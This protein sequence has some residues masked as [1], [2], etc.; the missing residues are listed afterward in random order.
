VEQE[1]IRDRFA[2]GVFSGLRGQREGRAAVGA[3]MADDR[4]GDCGI[5]GALRG[6][7]SASRSRPRVRR[8][9]SST[10]S[11]DH[12]GAVH[13]VDSRKTRLKAGY[14][15]KTDRL[16]AQ[17]LADALRRD[18]VVGIYLPAAP[19]SGTCASCVGIGVISR[20]R[21]RA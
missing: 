20:A 6:V 9:R 11:S 12:V 2:Q 16:D 15:A 21:R 10:A 13:V 1:Y 5:G 14:A 19:I 18:S 17:R 3:T 7:E 8:G 4:R